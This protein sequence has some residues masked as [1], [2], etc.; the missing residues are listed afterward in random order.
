MSSSFISIEKYKDIDKFK[1]ELQKLEEFVTDNEWL[2][3]LKYDIALNPDLSDEIS[4][5]IDYIDVETFTAE[6]YND[7]ILKL[8]DECIKLKNDADSCDDKIEKWYKYRHAYAYYGM[9]EVITEGSIITE[10][11]LNEFKKKY[12]DNYL[13]ELK[14]IDNY[15][16]SSLTKFNIQNENNIDLNDEIV[17]IYL[18]MKYYQDEEHVFH[19]RDLIKDHRSARQSFEEIVRKNYPHL[20]KVSGKSLLMLVILDNI[21]LIDINILSRFILV[22]ENKNLANIIGGKG[23]G[24]SILNT[25]GLN[26]PETYLISVTSLKEGL[27]KDEIEKLKNQNYAVRSS[28]TVEDNENNSFA[29]LFISKLNVPKDEIYENVKC[30]RDS[31]NNERVNSY[32]EHFNTDNP[33][34]SVV[35]QKFKEPILSGVWIGNNINS[36]YLEW[37]NG[38]GKKLVSGHV[39]PTSEKWP[40]NHNNNLNVDGKNVGES[41]LEL[42]Q[43]LNSSAD[44]E[45]CILDDKLVWLQY[46]PVTKKIEYKEENTT[47]DSFIGV[48][49][50]SGTVIGKPIYLEESEE[51]HIFE[52]GSILLTDYT[53]PDWVPIILRSSGIITAEGG[54]L[55]HT[56]I[57]SR[58]LGIP[59]VTGLGYDAIEKLKDEEQIEVN[60]NNG[61]V[62]ILGEKVMNNKMGEYTDLY[63]EN[64]NLTGEK[65]FRK[66]GTKLIVPEGRYSV[67]VLA[68]IENSKGEFLFQMT[69]KRKKNVWATTGGHVKSGQ[70]SKEAIIEEIK[71][72]LGI[73]INEDEVKLFKTYKYDD[74]FKD[75][76][77]IKKDIDINSLTYEKDE[78]E[79]VKYLTKDE[80][81]DLINNNGNIRKTNIDAFLE[82][83]KSYEY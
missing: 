83:I 9:I 39:K 45:W 70:T 48:A 17:K 15:K 3:M 32:V 24:L 66:K 78:V 60:G 12:S 77:Y 35:V 50:S 62:K 29:G 37:V 80:I 54:F 44:L 67:V 41:C 63:D 59:C 1:K 55:S 79:Y 36:G 2:T 30:V 72:E 81:L 43:K 53:D 10:K 75:V 11:I 28:A 73:D 68:F 21:P 19:E 8:K 14:K 16:P 7:L 69:S 74:A 82:L 22:N 33:Y 6:D 47:E 34:M 31:I 52:D 18:L 27:Y 49:A 4:E 46:R 51:E 26:V 71:E 64:K 38:N 5:I 20:K 42:Q 25:Y 76:F 57:I 13:D 61:S 56:A 65:L 40:N 23:L 58:E